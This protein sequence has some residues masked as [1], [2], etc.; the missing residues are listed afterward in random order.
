MNMNSISIV[1]SLYRSEAFIAKY[2]RKLEEIQKQLNSAGID[3]EVILVANDPTEV[4]LSEIDRI[5][6]LHNTRVLHV[7]REPLYASWNRGV[8]TAKS[9]IVGFWNVDDIRY[10]D[11]MIAAYEKLQNGFDLVDAGFIGRDTS[12]PDQGR[13]ESYPGYSQSTISPK[14]CVSPFFMFTQDLFKQAGEFR[15]DFKIAGDFEW[16]TRPVVRQAKYAELDHPG[17]EFIIH[18]SNLS[19]SK[20][21]LE[22]VEINTVLLWR[23][24]YDQL[25]PVD[26][27]LMQRKWDELNKGEFAIPDKLQAW[28]WGQGAKKRYELYSK[29]R[30]SHPLIRRIRLAL[31]RRGLVSSVEWDV[32]NKPKH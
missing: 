32:H 21:P 26:P 29:E 17:G 5:T 30:S 3:L 15:D 18:G 9:P 20:N 25:R 14:L 8:E 7:G 11:Y 4:E 6:E 19:N 24:A 1:T 22:W 13:P 31:A 28:L 23:E 16:C 10:A 12:K 2:R 27:Q